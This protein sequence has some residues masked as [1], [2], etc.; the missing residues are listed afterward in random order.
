MEDYLEKLKNLIEKKNI[1]SFWVFTNND[2]FKPIKKTKK[3]IIEKLKKY[4][5]KYG[6][7]NIANVTI[8]IRLNGLKK[9]DWIFAIKI[10]IYEIDEN[11]LINQSPNDTWSLLLK[12]NSDELSNRPFDMNDIENMI[13]IVNEKLIITS[14]DGI[15]YS[16]FIKKIKKLKNK[17]N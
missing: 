14:L 5:N 4:P 11:G 6:S 13:S 15:H 12:Y 3:D 8:T 1:K 9:N 2:E 10:D 16:D 17:L 7:Q